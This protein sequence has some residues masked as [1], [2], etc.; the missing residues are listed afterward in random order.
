[1]RPNF[2][3]SHYLQ[4]IFKLTNLFRKVQHLLDASLDSV[5]LIETTLMFFRA[6]ALV[7]AKKIDSSGFASDSW[8]DWFS[9]KNSPNDLTVKDVE[10]VDRELSPENWNPL[11]LLDIYR[12][13]V[14]TTSGVS[15]DVIRTS[16]C[17]ALAPS[18]LSSHD[19][20][21]KVFDHFL[22]MEDVEDGELLSDSEEETGNQLTGI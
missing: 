6:R 14:S 17:H 5:R 13:I 1:M 22:V 2:F 21:K 7:E 12:Q 16:L 11:R 20:M 8:Q 19:S 15:S 3:S 4:V 10:K 18:N 9:K